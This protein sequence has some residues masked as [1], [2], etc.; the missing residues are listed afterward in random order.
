ME[1]ESF[2]ILSFCY[3]DDIHEQRMEIMIQEIRRLSGRN[4]NL[5]RGSDN[6]WIIPYDFIVKD[7]I[8]VEQ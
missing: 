8:P 4:I 6:K 5:E 1:I 3:R 2:F 7:G